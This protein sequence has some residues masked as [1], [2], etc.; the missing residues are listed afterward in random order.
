MSV[1]VKDS[2][3]L[4]PTSSKMVCGRQLCNIIFYT[5]T[6]NSETIR[7]KRY[8]QRVKQWVKRISRIA[9]LNVTSALAS[10]IATRYHH[11]THSTNKERLRVMPSRFPLIS[12]P[13]STTLPRWKGRPEVG[14]REEMDEEEKENR[15]TLLGIGWGDRGTY[16][17]WVVVVKY[18]AE[19]DQ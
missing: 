11:A 6:A 14:W 8:S 1:F 3:N 16:S 2:G 18:W 15:M 5:R 4:Q 7:K 10:T 12:A 13:S 9:F 17:D 19:C